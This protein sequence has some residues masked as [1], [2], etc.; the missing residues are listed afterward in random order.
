[1]S[2]IYGNL[3][4]RHGDR[5][6]PTQAGFQSGSWPCLDLKFFG[7]NEKKFCDQTYAKNFRCLVRQFFL[8]QLRLHAVGVVIGGLP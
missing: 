2:Q 8:T 5:P 4:L 1:M 3:D 7:Q 6:H